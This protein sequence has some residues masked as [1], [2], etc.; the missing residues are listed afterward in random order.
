MFVFRPA[1]WSASVEQQ[2]RTSRCY[3]AVAPWCP[4]QHQLPV[5]QTWWIGR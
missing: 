3:R 1:F 5:L 2:I 4:A